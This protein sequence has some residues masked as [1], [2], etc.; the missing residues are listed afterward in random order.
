MTSERLVKISTK[1]G[2]VYVRPSRVSVISDLGTD[3]GPVPGHSIMIVDGNPV[4]VGM[5][6]ES[7]MVAL[8]GSPL[9]GTNEHA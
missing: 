1:G 4:P 2:V 8:F 7:L 3:K 5:T 6:K 9:E